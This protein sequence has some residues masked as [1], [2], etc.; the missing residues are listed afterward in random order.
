VQ[1]LRHSNGLATWHHRIL[2]LLHRFLTLLTLLHQFILCS[3]FILCGAFF[4]PLAFD[5][6]ALPPA[7]CVPNQSRSDEEQADA[8]Q[9]CCRHDVCLSHHPVPPPRLDETMPLTAKKR[10][11]KGP[12]F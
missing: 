8:I 9:L 1:A 4:P 12:L 10:E 2:T 11:E 7:R 6:R 5:R 3:D